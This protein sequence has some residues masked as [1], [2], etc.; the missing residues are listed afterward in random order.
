LRKRWPQG[1]SGAEEKTIL[2]AKCVLEHGGR[3]GDKEKAFLRE[4]VC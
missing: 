1:G 3:D 4:T 2:E